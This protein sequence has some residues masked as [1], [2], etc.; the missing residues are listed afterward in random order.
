MGSVLTLVPRPTMVEA[1][2]TIRY[3]LRSAD[4]QWLHHSLTRLDDGTLR[5]TEVKGWRWIG[6]EKQLLSVRAKFP[7]TREFERIRLA[8]DQPRI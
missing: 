6:T 8:A 7:E 2:G 5:C 1:S 3:A 4:S